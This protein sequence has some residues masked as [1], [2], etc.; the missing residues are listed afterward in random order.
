MIFEKEKLDFAD[1]AFC[2]YY[3]LRKLLL[4]LN[5][6]DFIPVFTC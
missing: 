6:K 1:R 4:N 3:I 5:F 2:F